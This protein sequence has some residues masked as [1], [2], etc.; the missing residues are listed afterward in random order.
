MTNQWPPQQQPAPYPAQPPYPQQPYPQQPYPQQ[1]QRPPQ[2]GYG[3]A[4][5]P[6]YPPQPAAGYQQH[7]PYAPTRPF[8]P[9]I[10]RPAALSQGAENFNWLMSSFVDRTADVDQAVVVSSDGLL[11]AVAHLDRHAADRLAAIVTGVRSLSDSASQ[12]LGRGELNHVIIE[13]RTAY[14]L[15]ASISGGSSLG[16]VCGTDADL[17]L[18]GYEMS[19]LVDRVGSQLTPELILEL[20]NALVSG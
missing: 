12:V 4:P 14:L 13:M 3:Q 7:A 1:G 5:A 18:V 19:L 15:V 20:K 17:G 9:A 8:P 11:M 10:A 2:P 16:V 6:Q